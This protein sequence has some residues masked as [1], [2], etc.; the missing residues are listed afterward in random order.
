MCCS[1]RRLVVGALMS[2]VRATSSA[3]ER[4]GRREGRGLGGSR[5]KWC[6]S[7]EVSAAPREGEK[8]A[9]KSGAEARRAVAEVWEVGE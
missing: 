4:Q 6:S 5:G 9:A 8:M 1:M 2:S 3:W 7:T